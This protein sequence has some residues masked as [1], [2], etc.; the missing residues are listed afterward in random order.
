METRLWKPG[1]T[2]LLSG[3]LMMTAVTGPVR[4][5]DQPATEESGVIQAG[6]PR[7]PV[8]KSR[9]RPRSVVEAPGTQIVDGTVIYA[10]GDCPPDPA[11]QYSRRARAVHSAK[12]Q[13]AACRAR[14]QYAND[15]LNCR[16]WY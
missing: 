1:V 15:C 4:S 12:C 13:C 10:R 11:C 14:C 7:C 8:Y 3:V 16:K 9:F 6:C 2:F 5:A